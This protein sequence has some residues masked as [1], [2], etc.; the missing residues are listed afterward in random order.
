MPTA[1]AI[2]TCWLRQSHANWLRVES[3]RCFPDETGGVLTGYINE[4]AM[5]LAE[6]VGP[7]PD[8]VHRAAR[9]VPD[10]AHHAREVKRIFTISAG[11]HTYLGDWHSHPNGVAQLSRMDRQTLRRIAR[12]PEAFCARPVMLLCAGTGSDWT[13][14]AFT[15]TT[16]HIRRIAPV[17]IRVYRD[18]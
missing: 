10:H 15:L 4:E 2:R 13:L 11:V 18:N 8:A 17:N 7:G 6:I 3:S 1:L 9:F 12:S 16:G 5:V 14:S